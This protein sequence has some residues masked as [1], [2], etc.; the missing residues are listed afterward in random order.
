MSWI[1]DLTACNKNTHLYNISGRDTMHSLLYFLNIYLALNQKHNNI[2][3]IFD[4]II[5]LY[6]KIID[7]INT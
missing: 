2:A 3:S 7:L 6:L 1:A 4:V 5:V